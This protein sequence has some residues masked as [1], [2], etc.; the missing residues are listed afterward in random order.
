MP[1]NVSQYKLAAGSLHWAAGW[2]VG[3]AALF[4]GIA[5]GR[6]GDCGVRGIVKEPRVFTGFLLLL[7]FVEALGL[8]GFIIS[9]LI[10]RTA[11]LHIG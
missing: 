3:L 7:I 5:I 4:A 6:L 10:H 9:Y 11:L 8:Y 2:T 1:N